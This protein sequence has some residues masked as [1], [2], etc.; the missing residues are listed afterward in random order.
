[1]SIFLKKNLGVNDPAVVHNYNF[2]EIKTSS[3][4]FAR[5][6]LFKL[7]LGMDE[8]LRKKFPI[9]HGPIFC[10]ITMNY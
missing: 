8:F 5:S 4:M 3:S 7:I 1:M 10:K 9:H 6:E 2:R